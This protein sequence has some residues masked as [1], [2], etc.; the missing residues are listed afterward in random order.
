VEHADR[1]AGQRIESSTQLSFPGRAAFPG[2]NVLRRSP[3]PDQVAANVR[4]ALQKALFVAGPTPVCLALRR[5]AGR[6]L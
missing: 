5:T 3:K 6:L 1:L 2:P 4:V